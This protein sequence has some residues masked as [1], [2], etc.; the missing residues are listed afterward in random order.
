MS[1]LDE[2]MNTEYLYSEP[3]IEVE[4]ERKQSKKGAYPFLAVFSLFSP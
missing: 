1:N 4:T 2:N 3:V